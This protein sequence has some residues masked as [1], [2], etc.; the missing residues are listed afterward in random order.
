MLG[1]GSADADWAKIAAASKVNVIKI[2]SL[3]GYVSN[4]KRMQ[5]AILASAEVKSLD[6]R[7]AGDRNLTGKLKGAGF[8]PD[9]VIAAGL[10]SNGAV[11]LFVNK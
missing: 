4:D 1:D 7:I 9:Q 10:E 5:A 8:A 2:S 11:S 6:T 3:K